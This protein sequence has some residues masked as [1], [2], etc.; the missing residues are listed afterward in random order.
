MYRCF[1]NTLR[2][3]PCGAVVRSIPKPK[4]SPQPAVNKFSNARAKRHSKRNKAR[5]LNSD[6]TGSQPYQ[7]PWQAAPQPGERRIL[8][9]HGGLF[10]AW[11]GNNINSLAIGSL[12]DL[13]SAHRQVDDPKDSIIEDV[14]WSDPQIDSPDVCLNRLRGAGILYGR[15]AVESFFKRNHLHGLIR[16][17]EGPDMRERRAEMNDML[18]GYS[19]DME[20]VSGFVATVFSTANY[21]EYSSFSSRFPL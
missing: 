21:R 20:L 11:H 1:V 8:V 13:A 18:D 14:L 9:T 19:L 6:G 5:A 16:G 15:G 17:H 10:R 2:E 4:S 7:L 3:L 12:G